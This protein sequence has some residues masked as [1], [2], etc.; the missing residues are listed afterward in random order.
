[1]DQLVVLQEIYASFS[2]GGDGLQE[3]S[4][5]AIEG[6][7]PDLMGRLFDSIKKGRIDEDACRELSL[8]L[9][10]VYEIKRLGD[11]CRKAGLHG[12][13]ISTYNRAL[14]LRSDPLLRP[15][16][17]NNLGQAYASQGDLAKAVFYYG[18]AADCFAREGDHTGLAH[19]LGNLGS[20][21][22]RSGEWDKA[23]EH[24][25]KSLK[26]FEEKGDDL[27]TAQMTGSLGRI[28]AD[29]GEQE[30]AARYFEKSLSDFQRLGDKRSAAWVQDRLGR[31]AG[32]K[33]DWDRA[34]CY[35]HQA[36]SLFQE[37][38]QESSQGLVLANIG[39]LYLQMGEADAARE[40]LE[41]ATLLI[42]RQ[43][44]PHYQNSLYCLAKT[45][46][47]LAKNCLQE[48]LNVEGAG[49]GE[50]TKNGEEHSKDRPAGQLRLE[51]SRLFARASDRYQE[52]ASTRSGGR[53]GIKVEAAMARCRSY[54]ARL[55]GQVSDE[56]ALSLAERAVAS[57]DIAAAHAGD[58]GK[59][60]ILG[61]Q[62][63]VSGMK[64]ARCIGLLGNEPSM[65]ARALTDAGEYLMGGAREWGS[66]EAG[67]FLCEA[68]K[69][70]NAGIQARISGRDPAPELLAAAAA[71]RQ[72]KEHTR[73]AER[74]GE[75]SSARMIA[76]AA[77]I[78]E[79]A[80][81]GFAEEVREA[82]TP[83]AGGREISFQPEKEA[84]LLLAG[85]MA[86]DSMSK[87]DIN[88]LRAEPKADPIART[89]LP[90]LEISEERCEAKDLILADGTLEASESVP[91]TA[92]DGK[93][94][95]APVKTDMACRSSCQLLLPPKREQYNVLTHTPLQSVD[96]FE[97][98]INEP[99]EGTFDQDRH[100]APQESEI[101]DRI[102]DEIDDEIEDSGQIFSDSV[103]DPAGNAEDA[104]KSPF[105]QSR[106]ILL[107]KALT[108]LTVML[109]AIEAI[110][111]LI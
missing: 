101:E 68:L 70:I 6:S 24:C 16:L 79:E 58:D 77:K 10:D 60:G 39:S 41:R 49:D 86:S 21:Y 73:A 87:I 37:L 23:V 108:V 46:S 50:N 40:P 64:E 36:L 1:M 45:Y 96:K 65:Q 63:T 56:E 80:A 5:K 74:G 12:L 99:G 44:K 55:C 51:A 111:Y 107:L 3:I 28:Y 97:E 89:D 25:Y 69:N 20:A 91:E 81:R 71:L 85:A 82:E 62:R 57:L 13:A 15:V 32:E 72:A 67:G 106:V 47:T 42:S 18:K 29:M 38:G 22:R 105:S 34:L 52:L 9:Q 76:R 90:A 92:N 8:K 59:A 75:E 54:L 31:I 103:P 88:D 104:R 19:V 35:F 98:S 11:I 100:D 93:G 78:L 84:L 4:N 102:E 17:Q 66:D 14:S 109:L 30:L 61:L 110:L 43:M 7:C 95:L 83:S 2:K 94:W 27:G 48:A 26:T 53:N 33:K